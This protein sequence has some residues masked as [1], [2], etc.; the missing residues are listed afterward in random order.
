MCEQLHEELGNPVPS[1]LHLPVL[2][3]QRGTKLSKQAHSQ[4]IDDR[5]AAVNLDVA[6]QLLGQN[7]PADAARLQPA[8]LIR[9]AT[10]TWRPERLPRQSEYAGFIAW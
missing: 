9:W 1:W 4:A 2:I 5:L 6:L 8:E 10:E 3:N 7:P